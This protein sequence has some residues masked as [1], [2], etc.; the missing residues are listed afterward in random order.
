MIARGARRLLA[1]AHGAPWRSRSSP[2]SGRRCRP[3]PSPE[4][5]R[6]D[7]H[8]GRSEDDA[9]PLTGSQAS[10]ASNA[11][12]SVIIVPR[13]HGS[14]SLR[15]RS[16]NQEGCQ[17]LRPGATGH[18]WFA[19]REPGL[20]LGPGPKRSLCH[21]AQDSAPKGL[22]VQGWVPVPL[23]SRGDLSARR[24]A[25]QAGHLSAACPWG[26]AGALTRIQP[27]E[28]ARVNASVCAS[29]ASAPCHRSTATY[30][31]SRPSS[32]AGHAAVRTTLVPA[33]ARERLGE[34]PA[35]L[36]GTVRPGWRPEGGPFP[37]VCRIHSPIGSPARTA[38]S[39]L[40]PQGPERTRLHSQSR[41]DSAAPSEQGRIV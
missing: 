30:D 20:A 15:R 1:G 12:S 28:L 10:A 27:R 32:Q 29:S 13:S 3:P 21:P 38:A 31:S 24:P 35:A 16:Q 2:S 14:R 39:R 37:A 33:A 4:P 34:S 8:R 41:L 23:L 17:G 6:R 25:P 5:T 19:A 40:R 22:T 36:L 11:T 26:L 7:D 18:I 9:E